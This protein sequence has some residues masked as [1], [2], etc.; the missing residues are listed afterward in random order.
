MYLLSESNAHLPAWGKRF[1][2]SY[3]CHNWWKTISWELNKHENMLFQYPLKITHWGM[4]TYICDIW[5][6]HHLIRVMTYHL[7]HIKA[8]SKPVCHWSVFASDIPTHICNQSFTLTCTLTTWLSICFT[9]GLWAHNPKCWKLHG[10]GWL[11]KVTIFINA[12]LS[13]DLPNGELV[14]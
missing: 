6:S 3:R 9:N 10:I 12:G 13:I 1:F 8:L 14:P 7:F 11:N 4:V 2:K 5:L